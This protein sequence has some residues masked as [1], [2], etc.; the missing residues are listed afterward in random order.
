MTRALIYATLVININHRTLEC[1]TID[2]SENAIDVGVVTELSHIIIPDSSTP[3]YI[4]D[5]R[6]IVVNSKNTR[7]AI[8]DDN[9]D[10]SWRGSSSNGFSTTFLEVIN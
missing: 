10:E 6:N 9:F 7:Q 4:G 1:S 5:S 8:S 3:H 2:R